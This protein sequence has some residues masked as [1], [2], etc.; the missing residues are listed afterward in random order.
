MPARRVMR[1]YHHHYHHHHHHHLR[2]LRRRRRRGCGQCGGVCE[3]GLFYLHYQ[4]GEQIVIAA[5]LVY[6]FEYDADSKLVFAS[7]E[8]TYTPVRFFFV[9]LHLFFY[10]IHP[11][12]GSTEL[13]YASRGLPR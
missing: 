5:A 11:E 6:C 7:E 1:T 13:Y 3:S 8:H 2:R 10:D 12:F 4:N 9:R